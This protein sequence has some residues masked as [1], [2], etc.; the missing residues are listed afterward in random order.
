MS[1]IHSSVP[2]STTS[3]SFTGSSSRSDSWC[4]GWCARG[5]AATAASRWASGNERPIDW[6][7]RFPGPPP[8][9]PPAPAESSLFFREVIFRAAKVARAVTRGCHGRRRHAASHNDG[10]GLARRLLGVRLASREPGVCVSTAA[11]TASAQFK[12]ARFAV[13]IR[14][15][16]SV[17]RFGLTGQDCD[18]CRTTRYDPI[19]PKKLRGRSH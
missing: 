7:N 1:A 10:Q 18:W 3:D 14:S 6:A 16:D 8:R 13:K 11:T 2:S 5:A 9:A 19:Y 15:Q 12:S 4:C 17:S